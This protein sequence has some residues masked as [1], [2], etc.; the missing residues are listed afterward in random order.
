MDPLRYGDKEVDGRCGRKILPF[1]RCTSRYPKEDES[2]LLQRTITSEH[3][4]SKRDSATTS[5]VLSVV[6][7]DALGCEFS[8]A[9][10][11]AWFAQVLQ[12]SPH[13]KNN[14]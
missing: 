11:V 13:M 5:W 12:G 7:S 6:D 8:F 14:F 9:A 2:Q 4:F 10:A 3:I 1:S